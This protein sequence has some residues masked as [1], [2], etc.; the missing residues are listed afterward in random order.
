MG[1][2]TVDFSL[3]DIFHPHLNSERMLDAVCIQ[4]KVQQPALPC[5][6]NDYLNDELPLKTLGS[7]SQNGNS[8]YQLKINS[9][10][11]KISLLV[12]GKK[13]SISA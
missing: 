6:M 3:S 8:N 2:S 10:K 7:R 5:T 11:Y 1:T 9:I 4:S 12:I 13:K